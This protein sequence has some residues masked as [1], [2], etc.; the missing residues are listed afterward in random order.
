MALIFFPLQENQQ[1]LRPISILNLGEIGD[2]PAQFNGAHSIIFLFIF[3]IEETPPSNREGRTAQL[4]ELAGERNSDRRD[5]SGYRTGTS[6]FLEAGMS[7]SRSAPLW[8]QFTHHLSKNSL[9][10]SRGWM[11]FPETMQVYEDNAVTSG[12]PALTYAN[13]TEGSCSG[14][15]SCHPRGRSDCGHSLSRWRSLPHRTLFLLLAIGTEIPVTELVVSDFGNFWDIAFLQCQRLC[16]HTFTTNLETY[17]WLA[18]PSGD[19]HYASSRRFHSFSSSVEPCVEPDWAHGWHH[20]RLLDESVSSFLTIRAAQ[21]LS[22]TSAT[23]PSPLSPR[24]TPSSSQGWLIP[25][26]HCHGSLCHYN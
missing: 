7:L 12:A 19:Y 25:L 17:T 3:L 26:L 15:C 23:I 9:R 13:D 18:P 14:R 22:V 21:W 6:A 2:T 4:I 11:N 10:G 5:H 24:L 1:G 16:S 8:S 20:S